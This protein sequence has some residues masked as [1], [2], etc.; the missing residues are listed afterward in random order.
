MG[1]ALNFAKY[2]LLTRNPDPEEWSQ[3]FLACG[4]VFAISLLL[5][6][7]VNIGVYANNGLAFAK[8]FF[9]LFLVLGG[10]GAVSRD[11]HNNK[12]L[13]LADFAKTRDDITTVNVVFAIFLV[14]YSYQGWENASKLS[15]GHVEE[16]AHIF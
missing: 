13:G 11:G 7:T 2:L 8:V 12:L 16:P 15:S 4:V 1:N 3:K 14:L 10:I 5:Y 6:R 9:L